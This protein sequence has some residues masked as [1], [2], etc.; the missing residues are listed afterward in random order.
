MFVNRLQKKLGGSL[1]DLLCISFLQYTD[2][3]V[4]FYSK[5][6]AVLFEFRVITNGVCLIYLN[7]FDDILVLLLDMLLEVGFICSRLNIYL[8]Y[9]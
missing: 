2:F 9:V 5:A 6:N 3:D 8:Y 7:Y 1:F 4:F